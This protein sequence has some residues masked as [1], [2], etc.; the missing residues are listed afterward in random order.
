[1]QCQFALLCHTA[2]HKCLLY[3]IDCCIR[4]YQVSKNQM[5]CSYIRVYGLVTMH[6]AHAIGSLVFHCWSY[7]LC[8]SI[9][10][11][12]AIALCYQWMPSACLTLCTLLPQYCPKADFILWDITK[13]VMIYNCQLTLK[14]VIILSLNP[15][16]SLFLLRPFGTKQLAMMIMQGLILQLT[17]CGEDNLSGHIGRN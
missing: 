17:V 3:Y 1:M 13:C 14:S 7:I 15:T 6:C 12:D 16:F 5:Q 9:H 4:I 10:S 8:A 2:F 11:R